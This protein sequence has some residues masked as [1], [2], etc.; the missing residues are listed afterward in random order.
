MNMDA[1][2]NKEIQ[3]VI[4]IG[5]MNDRYLSPEE[6]QFRIPSE[7]KNEQLLDL[8]VAIRNHKLEPVYPLEDQEKRTFRYWKIPRLEKM[9]HDIDMQR[10]QWQITQQPA[11]FDE[12]LKR[13]LIDEAFYS[14]WIEGAKTTRRRAEEIVRTGAAPQDRS[15]QMCLN[16]FR[17][18]EF[19]LKNL[20][21]NVDED[22]VCE[23]HRITTTKT[24][25]PEDEP[26]AGQYRNDRTYVVDGSGPPIYTPPPASDV[27]AMMQSLYTWVNFDGVDAFFLHPVLKAAIMHFYT[28][29][30]HPFFDG[31]GRTAR[32]L[33]YHYLLKHGYEFMQFFSI[34]KAIAAKRKAY[35]QAI[36]DVER[37]DSD[38][39]YFLLFSSQMILDAITTVETAKQTETSLVTWLGNINAS[40]IALNPR[41]EKLFKLHFRQSLFPITI[42]KYQKLNRVVYETARTDLL[43]LCDKGLLQ[44]EKK[45]REFVFRMKERNPL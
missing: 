34:S 17:S 2:K 40:G 30:V 18:M 10:A 44:M 13:S 33:M 16:N 22:L 26:F 19:I 8:I 24:L 3:K 1:N 25:D 35:Y 21:R 42:K 6:I 15:E 4:F 39:T 31:N 9:L 43:D 28:V 37:F 29:Y 41:Q 7:L 14:S 27:R 20:H 12:L 11:I 36:L 38:L 32:A 23:L 45:G 5:L